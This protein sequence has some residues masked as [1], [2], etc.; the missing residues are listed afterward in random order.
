MRPEEEGRSI[1]GVRRVKD[2]TARE[3][4]ESTNLDSEGLGD[5]ELTIR[6]PAWV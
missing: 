2:T 5:T 4:T 3:P 6:E 1:V